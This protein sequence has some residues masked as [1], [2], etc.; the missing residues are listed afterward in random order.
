MK[1]PELKDDPRSVEKWPYSRAEVEKMD[2]FS[3]K[4]AG[5]AGTKIMK[6]LGID[7]VTYNGEKM[8]YWTPIKGKHYKL[9]RMI[10]TEKLKQN[11]QV[12]KVLLETE[13]LILLPDHKTNPNDP[14]AWK[15]NQ[16]WMEIRKDLQKSGGS[17][18]E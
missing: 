15:Y 5:D 7:W 14:P 8:P 1:Y 3:A 4:A 11:P 9:I 13:D 6:K 16:I 10:M 17:F 18:P 12:K 2:G